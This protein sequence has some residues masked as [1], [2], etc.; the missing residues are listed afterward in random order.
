MRKI[1]KTMENLTK[2]NPELFP[3]LISATFDEKNDILIVER[4]EDTT[5]DTFSDL[6]HAATIPIGIDPKSWNKKG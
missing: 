2:S 4:T 1:L 3:G 6:A 5:I